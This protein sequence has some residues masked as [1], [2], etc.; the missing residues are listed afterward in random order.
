LDS[1]LYCAGMVMMVWDAESA[2][3]TRRMPFPVVNVSNSS[4]AWP[5][6]ANVQSDD[7]AVGRL[8]AELLLGRGYRHFLAI[9]QAGRVFSTERL[10]GFAE[11]IAAAGAVPHAVEVTGEVPERPWSPGRYLEQMWEQLG[12]LIQALPME[13]GIFA[14]SDWLAWPVLRLLETR[15]PE[16]LHTSGLL[17][18]DNM[19]DAFFD[20]RKSMGLSSILP[21]F[22]EAGRLSLGLLMQTGADI[23]AV[24][25]RC[26]P[27]RWIERASTAGPACA[28]PVTARLIRSL[29]NGVRGE[30]SPPLAD[31]ARQNGMS[32][33]SM[34]HKF[35][36]F[37]GKSAREY[38]SELRVDYGKQL[39][40]TDRRPI[41]EV[42]LAC[43]YADA[44]AFTNAFKRL[45]GQ[46]PK[47]WRQASTR[48]G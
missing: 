25:L 31:L 28:D 15:A 13:T 38:L 19:H 3:Q 12:P 37:L 35:Q 14:A 44:P 40:A 46:S 9:G 27:E 29:W 26:Q 2:A 21:G 6:M 43:G 34:E 4:G 11:R 23:T 8:G 22:R 16:R 24:R 30:R 36:R 17:G 20:P 48:V 42:A 18:V 47:D 7:P 5:G 33:R 32:L 39:L 41:G 45:T 1:L 10:A